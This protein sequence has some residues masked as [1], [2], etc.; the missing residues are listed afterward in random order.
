[1]S[2]EPL[3]ARRS[4]APACGLLLRPSACVRAACTWLLAAWPMMADGR[5]GRRSSVHYP[6][7]LPTGLPWLC[8]VNCERPARACCAREAPH[9]S[10]H[11]TSGGLQ[12]HL[13][14]GLCREE[15]STEHQRASV[16]PKPTPCQHNA[17]ASSVL[18]LGA[19]GTI[20]A[21]EQES[22]GPEARSL[23]ESW[24]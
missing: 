15:T 16:A 11:P 24:N 13:P 20:G 14:I 2:P 12:R 5:D 7:V 18:V 21:G 19:I 10:G 1:M 23:T 4:P 8:F 9:S 17:S 22:G 3:A 6:L